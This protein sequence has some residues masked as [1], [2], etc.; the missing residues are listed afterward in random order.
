MGFGCIYIGNTGK[1]IHKKEIMKNKTL[2][3]LLLGAG[4]LYLIAAKK[5]PKG[6]V[7]VPEPEKITREQFERKTFVQKAI[8]VVKKIAE[9]VKKK[10]MTAKQKQ[11]IQTLSSGRKLFGSVGQFPDI[12]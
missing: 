3:Y 11:A 1:R 5:K 7:I 6:R 9:A 4:A 2:I 10:K 12:Y 8:P